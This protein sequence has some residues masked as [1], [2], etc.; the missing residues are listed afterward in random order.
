MKFFT[1]NS[2]TDLIN[3]VD[4]LGFLPFFANSIEGF[5]IEEHITRDCWYNSDNGVWSAWE[6]KGPVIRETG[7]AYGKF[8]EKKR[9]I[10][11][12][13]GFLILPITAATVMILTPG[14]TTVL[15]ITAIKLS[16]S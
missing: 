9:V 5:S 4:E 16:L 2:K 15:Q 6:W 13:N 14:T 8:F 3:A 7:C 10:S 12:Q 11:V 1:I